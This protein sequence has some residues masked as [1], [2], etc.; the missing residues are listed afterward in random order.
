LAAKPKY[1]KPTKAKAPASP[2]AGG[3][4]TLHVEVLQNGATL[5]STWVPTKRS[6]DLVLTT[7]PGQPFYLPHYP[8]PNNRL[9]FLNFDNGVPTLLVGHKWEGFCTSG[10]HLLNFGRTEKKLRTVA[11]HKGDYASIAYDDLR[12]M[13]RVA[14]GAP[15]KRTEPKGTASAWRRSLVHAYFPSIA[16]RRAV[17]AAVFVAA[18][19]VG[20]FAFGLAKRPVSTPRGL[21]DIDPEYALPFVGAAQLK[22][23]PE[24]LQD[25]LDRSTLVG[26]V[27]RYY[28]AVTAALMGWVGADP[29][30]L[31]L[32]SIESWA[33]RHDEARD[34][35]AEKIARQQEVDRLQ[36]LKSGVGILSVP[37]VVGESM[38]G[39]MARVIDKIAIMQE[40]FATNLELRRKFITEFPKDP[41]Y[42]YDEYKN[43]G[44]ARNARTEEFMSKVK[45]FDRMTNEALMYHEADAAA[46]AATA[47]QRRMGGAGATPPRP[48]IGFPEGARF[49]SFALDMDFRLAD[50]KLSQLQA[51]QYGVAVAAKG[52]P[53]VKEPLVGEIEPQVIE[54]FIRQHKFQLQLCYEL[55]LRRNEGAEGTMEW[56]WRVDSRGLITDIALVQSSIQD[57]RM[58]QC[59]RQKIATWRFPRPRRG[60]VEVSYPFEFARSKG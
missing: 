37:T 34:R 16:E 46:A 27:I 15:A 12:I 23:A 39:S 48:P 40:G 58:A 7:E 33:A 5:V 41:V 1:T 25:S 17:V 57:Q 6:G 9:A 43:P 44:G 21:G 26:S 10:G 22:N 20:G 28:G 32:P 18:V 8:L 2:R 35:R 29:R 53:T 42:A 14:L 3:R 24:A 54:N 60:A 4:L 50:L 30:L 51:S 52:Q 45:V 56:R 47:S 31:P 55:A 13:V 49:A 38:D 36:G 19:V 59:I 11:M